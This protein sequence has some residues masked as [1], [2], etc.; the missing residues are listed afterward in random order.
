MKTQIPNRLILTKV[1]FL[2]TILIAWLFLGSTALATG[3]HVAP[4]VLARAPYNRIISL[5]GAHTENL[6]ALGAVD[7]LIGID[8][9][10]VQQPGVKGKPVF[11]YH[12]DPE[13]FLAAR[14]DLVL[15]RPMIER[16]YSRLVQRLERSGIRVVSLQP[17]TVDQLE[18]YWRL[19][20]ELCGKA[21]QADD[22][23]RS[24]E[25]AVL[26]F[27]GLSAQVKSPQRVYFEAIH[28]KMKTFT[29]QAMATFA[30]E[31]AGGVN[32][33]ADAPVRENNN[34]AVYGKE[35]LLSHAA[36]ID[37][38]LTQ[39]GAMNQV[40][41]ETIMAEPGFSA[42]KA[43]KAGRVFQVNETIVSRPTLG[44]LKGIYRIGC[45]LYPDIYCSAG[46]QI[47]GSV[48]VDG[49]HD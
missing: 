41:V 25:T 10:S 48:G 33:A 1:P 18:G 2:G 23:H 32:V 24:F 22:M 12:D 13:R 5:Y 31:T 20:G 30:V 35:R 34:I 15:I 29:P 45:L 44:L 46:R 28:T 11:S 38:F 21:S 8:G 27:K 14:P 9:Q 39:Q 26:K 36:E 7:Q 4:S 40:P 3:T 47:L 49:L 17:T 16:G 42:I 37:V 43:V 6:L 19:L